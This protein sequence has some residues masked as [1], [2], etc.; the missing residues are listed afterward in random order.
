MRTGAPDLDDV[1]DL[2]AADTEGLLHAAALA[3]AQVRSVAEAVREGVAEPLSEL[4]PRSVVIVCAP[5]GPAAGAT[6]M[7]CA[8]LATRVDVPIVYLG[9]ARLDRSA[10]RRRSRR[11]R[12]R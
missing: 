5:G 9:V 10:R 2:I 3:G 8:M 4:R 7:V 12:W 11:Y 6:A 1:D